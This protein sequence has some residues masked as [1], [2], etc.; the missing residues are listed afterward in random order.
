MKTEVRRVAPH[1]SDTFLRLLC[2][3]FSIDFNRAQAYFNQ[4]SF[5][6]LQRKWALFEGERMVSILT[7]V[8]LQF[9]WGQGI[10]IAGVAT[11]EDAR[12]QG[13]AATLLNEVMAQAGQSGYS[14]AYLF[15][16]KLE[17]YGRL[18]FEVIDTVIRAEIDAADST[19]QPRGLAEAEVQEIYE[20]WSLADPNRLR[21]DA[22]RWRY[23]KLTNRVC[24]PFSGGYYSLESG[25]L[26]EFVGNKHPERW[27]LPRGTHWVGLSTM[28]DQ[29]GIP[30]IGPE[31]VELFLMARGGQG[32]PGMFMTDQF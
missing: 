12:G 22:R 8:P 7:T 31:T 28:R 10:G 27:P 24:T 16:T 32:I 23:W 20:K 2:E 18:G 1:E 29:L 6:D 21:R 25:T 15:A 9:G 5:T 26:R 4:S 13:H 3:I 14:G 19:S 30:T 11:V 17:L